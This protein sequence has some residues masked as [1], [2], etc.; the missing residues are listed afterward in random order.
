MGLLYDFIAIIIWPF[1]LA[2]WTAVFLARAVVWLCQGLLNLIVSIGLPAL[3]FLAFVCLLVAAIALVSDATP[4]LEGYGRFEPTLFVEHW[5]SIAPN[6]VASAQQAVSNSTH[7]MIWN[8]GIAPLINLPTYLIFGAL[9]VLAAMA[10]RR[11]EK[12]NVFVN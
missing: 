1:K 5:R 3:R 11:R 4:E 7:P 9:G 6:S 10:G 12:L 8:L 2:I